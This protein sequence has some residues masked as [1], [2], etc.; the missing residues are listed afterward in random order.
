[1][2]DVPSGAENKDNSDINIDG[3]LSQSDT[4]DDED[5]EEEEFDEM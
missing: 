2:V 5:L 3:I 4:D 1:M